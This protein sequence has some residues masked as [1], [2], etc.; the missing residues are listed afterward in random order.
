MIDVRNVQKSKVLP[1]ENSQSLINLEIFS[2]CRQD[3]K[4]RIPVALDSVNWHTRVVL[5]SSY[6]LTMIR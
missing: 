5:G 1:Q 3:F 4:A 6:L 2:H